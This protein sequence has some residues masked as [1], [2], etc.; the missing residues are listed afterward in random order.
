MFYIFTCIFIFRI[1]TFTHFFTL[2]VLFICVFLTKIPDICFKFNVRFVIRRNPLFSLISCYLRIWSVYT[3]LSCLTKDVSPRSLEQLNSSVLFLF[4]TFKIVV[5]FQK[6][7]DLQ[8]L[9]LANWMSTTHEYF[10]WDYIPLQQ[11]YYTFSKPI[12]QSQILRNWRVKST[13][14]IWVFEVHGF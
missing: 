11:I 6:W 1:I 13:Y 14:H 2:E 9:V 12:H 10:I 7:K 8:H 5:Q 3:A 4:F